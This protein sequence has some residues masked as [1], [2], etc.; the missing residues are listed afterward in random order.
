MAPVMAA[1]GEA[2]PPPAPGKK[3]SAVSL[4][5]PGSQLK[6]VMLPR[7]DENKRLSAVLNAQVMTLVSDDVIAGDDV[8]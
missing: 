1:S 6:G 3:F 8:V 2:A 7:Y 5:P 4:L